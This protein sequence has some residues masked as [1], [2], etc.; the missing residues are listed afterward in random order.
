MYKAKAVETE[1]QQPTCLISEVYG[2]PT[3]N[4]Q[5]QPPTAL[6]MINGM[7]S[8]RWNWAQGSSAILIY[9]FFVMTG[10]TASNVYHVYMCN[11]YEMR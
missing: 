6:D 11:T 9:F 5:Q 4:N 1:Q 10:A 8:T 3:C 7:S 2:P